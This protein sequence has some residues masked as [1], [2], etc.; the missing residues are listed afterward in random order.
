MPEQF[1]AGVFIGVAAGLANGSFAL[2]LHYGRKWQWENT[3]VVFSVL[4]QVA[5]PWG[6]AWLATPHLFA[7]LHGSPWSFLLPGLIAGFVWGVAQVMYGLGLAMV[8]IAIANSVI[9]GMAATAGTLGPLF[10]YAPEKLLTR[11]GLILLASLALIVGGIYLYGKA[12]LRKE[13]E[14]AGLAGPKPL[15]G[16]GFRTGMII[17]LITGALG[18]AFIYGLGSSTRLLKAAAAAG[19]RPVFAACIA[20]AV[21]FGAGFVPNLTYCLYKM[22]KNRSAGA[23]IHSG[24]F[25]RNSALAG[26]MAVLWFGGVLMYGVAAG[27]IG[28]L[29]PSVGFGLFVSATVLSANFLG[30]LAGEWK[31]ASSRTVRSFLAGMLLIVAAIVVIALGVG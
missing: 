1:L 19:A 25:L 26:L 15:V 29:G 13:K 22:R 8:G 23:L 10:A 4:S 30:W 7:I 5:L 6:V 31:G 12:G 17:C 20:W 16:G 21:T 2:P 14:A 11:T 9:A 24:H 18:T 28:R 3:W 27:K